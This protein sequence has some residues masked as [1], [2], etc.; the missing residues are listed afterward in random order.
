MRGTLVYGALVPLLAVACFGPLPP[1]PSERADIMADMLEPGLD[2]GPGA[3]GIDVADVAE[4]GDSAD[5]ADTVETADVPP[6]VC[7]CDDGRP[8]TVDTCDPANGECLH[9]DAA[10]ECTEAAECDDSNECTLDGCDATTE[11][12][13]HEPREG[14]GCDDGDA[15]T[16]LDT[17]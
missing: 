10:C 2:E 5:V 12:C 6:E 14:E 11:L 13:S 16:A 8:C 9:N 1:R 3:D 7:D 17:C 4:V 15:C